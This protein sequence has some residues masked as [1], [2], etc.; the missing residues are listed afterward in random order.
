MKR[1]FTPRGQNLCILHLKKKGRKKWEKWEKWKRNLE[2]VTQ[3]DYLLKP[4]ALTAKKINISKVTFHFSFPFQKK[5]KTFESWLMEGGIASKSL[6]N[7][8]NICCSFKQTE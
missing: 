3:S 5:K 6:L 4:I 8:D 7:I 1:T 2:E